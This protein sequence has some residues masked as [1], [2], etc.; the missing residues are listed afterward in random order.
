MNLNVCLFIHSLITAPFLC[1]LKQ[2]NNL[3]AV[4]FRVIYAQLKVLAASDSHVYLVQ[5]SRDRPLVSLQTIV[6]LSQAY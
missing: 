3:S 1:V 4:M 2:R 5:V 6:Q